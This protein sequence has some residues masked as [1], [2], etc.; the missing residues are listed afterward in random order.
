MNNVTLSAVAASNYT[1]PDGSHHPMEVRSLSLGGPQTTQNYNLAQGWTVPSYLRDHNNTASNSFRLHYGSASLDLPGSLVFGGYDQSRVLGPVSS[2]DLGFN[3]SIVAS[4]IDISFGTASGESA[5]SN[6]SSTGSTALL[7][8]VQSSATRISTVFSPPIPYLLLSSATRDE[9]ASNPPV[10]FNPGLGLYTWNTA[11]DAYTTILK[12]L[13][14][15]AFTFQ[16]VGTTF[17]T[18]KVPVQL[19]NLT[20]TAPLTKTPTQYFPHRPY[21][22]EN[23]EAG[24]GVYFL[25]RAFL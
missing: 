19:L 16:D 11:D 21:T 8:E 2:F 18:I 1:L 23:T 7:Q 22:T 14:Y 3:N 15:L 10:T 5:F 4:L 12:S 17:L 9:I 25:G 13:T 6:T 24:N 20:F